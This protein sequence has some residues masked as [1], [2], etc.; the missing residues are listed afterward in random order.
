MIV[1]LPNTTTAKIGKKLQELR[2]TGGV[3]ALG[4]VLSLLVET[5]AQDLEKAIATANGASKPPPESL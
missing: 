4:R 1:D 3:V 2:E 5:D